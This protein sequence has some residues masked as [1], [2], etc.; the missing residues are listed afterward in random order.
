MPDI[1][2]FFLYPSI[3]SALLP[4]LVFLLFSKRIAGKEAM[5]LLGYIVYS[6]LTDLT[7][8]SLDFFRISKDSIN[9]F[10][11]S[12]FTIVE[13]TAFALFFKYILRNIAIRRI[14]KISIFA[15][16]LFAIVNLI[17]LFNNNSQ[18]DTFPVVFQAICIMALC[19][20]YFFDQIREPKTLFIYTTF[21]FWAVTGILVYL[22]GTF[23]IYMFTYSM[24]D[25][26]L[27]RY[28]FINYIF[29][30]IKNL[31][32]ALAFYVKSRKT[33]SDLEEQSLGFYI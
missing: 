1:D 19:V 28:W 7:S 3:F 11:Y 14:I 22:S 32:L 15:F 5:V 13:F 23:F 9:P 33:K 21:E 24:T 16:P 30:I 2:N 10:L 20:I 12:L 25:E 27:D 17:L 26:E 6:F 8:T 29:N 4:L 31:F 18:F